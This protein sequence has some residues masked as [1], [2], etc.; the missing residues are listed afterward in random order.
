MSDENLALAHR[1]W[2][3]VARGD[4]EAL[5]QVWAPDI[6]WHVTGRNPWTGTHVGHEAICDYLADVG[7][8]GEAYDTRLDDLL[9]SK[10]RVVLVCHI[11]ARR[12]RK[13]V[14]TDQVLMARVEG[15]K[16]IEV[17]TV[18]LDPAAFEGFYEPAAAAA[19]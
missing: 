1:A 19:S 10:D 4:T 3:A 18:P 15:G 14:E 6:V 2:E 11:T 5:K 13:T 8:A 16:M 7:E 9:V 17:W 12:G